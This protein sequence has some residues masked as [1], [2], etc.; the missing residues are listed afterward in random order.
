MLFDIYFQKD[1]SCMSIEPNGGQLASKGQAMYVT[2]NVSV[3]DPGT[4]KNILYIIMEFETVE[5]IQYVAV[6]RNLK[7]G[8]K[9]FL[10]TFF[11]L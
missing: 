10:I 9:I 5:V 11:F 8:T 2:L 7:N 3:K 1:D 4:Y 6:I